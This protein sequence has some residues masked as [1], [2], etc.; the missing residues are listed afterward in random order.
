MPVCIGTDN[1]NLE[2]LGDN[3]EISS[4]SKVFAREAGR[5]SDVTVVSLFM[6]RLKIW[7]CCQPLSRSYHV[8]SSYHIISWHGNFG[9][10]FTNTCL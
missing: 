9:L 7:P 6:P 5:T 3:A 10:Y 8:T 2:I 4:V 1:A